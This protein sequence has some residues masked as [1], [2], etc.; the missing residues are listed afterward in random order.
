MSNPYQVFFDKLDATV[1]AFEGSM[2]FPENPVAKDAVEL[3]RRAGFVL[4]NLL[5]AQAAL[6]PHLILDP[7]PDV[8]EGEA[9]SAPDSDPE[10]PLE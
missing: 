9:E 5:N 10:N 6:Y 8:V 7:G 3:L 4:G 2:G 1:A